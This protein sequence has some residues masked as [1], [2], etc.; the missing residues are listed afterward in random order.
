MVEIQCLIHNSSPIT[1]I[2]N[3][4]NT[5]PRIDNCLFKILLIFS[6]HLRLGLPKGRFPVGLPVNFKST[7]PFSF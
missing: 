2:L 1:P 4:I 3:Q 5:V 7:L 6:S